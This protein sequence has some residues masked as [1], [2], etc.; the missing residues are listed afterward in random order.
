[1]NAKDK[2][3]IAEIV[4]AVLSAKKQESPR[5]TGVQ[6]QPQQ[7]KKDIPPRKKADIPQILNS[8]SAVQSKTTLGD[9]TQREPYSF[10]ISNFYKE[11]NIQLATDGKYP[12]SK[13]LTI[14]QK[15]SIIEK[16]LSGLAQKQQ[17]KQT[18]RHITFVKE[19]IAHPPTHNIYKRELT[20]KQQEK[21]VQAWTQELLRWTNDN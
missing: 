7:E 18:K 5:K 12:E 16:Q 10:T 21:I 3:E 15:H 8:M 4:L 14:E 6:N 1:M 17:E 11:Y 13:N 9:I 2:K 19:K 20:P